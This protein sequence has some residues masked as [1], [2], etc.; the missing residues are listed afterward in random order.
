LSWHVEPDLARAGI[1]YRKLSGTEIA[2]SCAAFQENIKS[3]ELVHVGQAELD[4]ALANARTRRTRDAETWDRGYSEDISPLVACAA[5][6]YRWGL[7]DSAPYDMLGSV[8]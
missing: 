7:L 4:V 6:S 5:A 3:G 2:A 1:D 8:L